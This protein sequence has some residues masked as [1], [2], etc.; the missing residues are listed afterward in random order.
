MNYSKQK[1]A[2]LNRESQP[3]KESVHNQHIIRESACFDE[4]APFEKKYGK[5]VSEFTESEFDDYAINCLYAISYVPKYY[6]ISSIKRY[7]HWCYSKKYISRSQEMLHPVYHLSENSDAY[8][9][10]I[11][12]EMFASFDHFNEFILS[13]VPWD[14]FDS[15][16]MDMA[17]FTLIYYGFSREEAAL[18]ERDEITL[19]NDGSILYIRNREIDNSDAI[20]YLLQ[21]AKQSTFFGYFKIG[22]RHFD[23]LKF[24]DNQYLLRKSITNQKNAIQ[25]ECLTTQVFTKMANRV[26]RKIQNSIECGN[27]K[28]STAQLWKSGRFYEIYKTELN[29]GIPAA[30]SNCCEIFGMK[31]DSSTR[32]K[33]M[34][35]YVVWRNTFYDSHSTQ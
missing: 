5:D 16:K 23:E 14:E 15:M 22:P 4:L 17:A 31:D 20:R 10:A 21:V 35:Q 7:L 33:I 11:R 8:A 19:S 29:K 30:Y 13:I 25:D 1:E 18:I 9:A 12:K 28:F 3:G 32:T 2:F 26:N 24:C 34:Q 27:K 6:R